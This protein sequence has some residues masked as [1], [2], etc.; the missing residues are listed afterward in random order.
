MLVSKG[1]I[2]LETSS[3]LAKWKGVIV[4][5]LVGTMILL[6]ASTA[7]AQPKWGLGAKVVGEVPFITGSVEWSN[8]K[9]ELGTYY[10]TQ[11]NV[12]LTLVSVDSKY[13]FFERG[14]TLRPYIGLKGMSIDVSSGIYSAMVSGGGAV[15]GLSWLATPSLN[16]EVG[17]GYLS[18]TDLTIGSLTLPIDIGGSIFEIGVNWRF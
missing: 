13:L 15:G 17:A 3:K 1:A 18:F 14:K 6:T 12:E 2:I 16:V 9:L 10:T 8:I 5:A 11:N 7:K 4:L